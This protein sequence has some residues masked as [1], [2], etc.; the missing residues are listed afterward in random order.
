VL[1]RTAKIFSEK[2]KRF[3]MEN[4]RQLQGKALRRLE[5][6]RRRKNNG[7][8]MEKTMRRATGTG[9]DSGKSSLLGRAARDASA[10]KLSIAPP[11][12]RPRKK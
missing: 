9:E 7:K 5:K 11:T 4:A 10:R 12:R 3:T 1:S 2:Y 6:I 8:T